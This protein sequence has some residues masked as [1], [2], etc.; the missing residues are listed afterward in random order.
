MVEDIPRKRLL[1]VDDEPAFCRFVRNVAEEL[2]LTVEMTTTG[3]ELMTTYSLFL[4]AT[5]VMDIVM[6]EIE[7]VELTQWLIGQGFTG[8]LILATGFAPNYANVA[9]RLADASAQ[10]KTET[11]LKP[12]GVDDLEAVLRGC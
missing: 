9:Q 1:V 8:K 2:D 4:P 3:T 6:P 7:G 11:L 5:I 12:V 10:F